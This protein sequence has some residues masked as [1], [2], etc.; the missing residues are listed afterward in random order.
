LGPR[1]LMTAECLQDLPEAPSIA[2]IGPEKE[3]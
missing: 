2:S 1:K 3:P